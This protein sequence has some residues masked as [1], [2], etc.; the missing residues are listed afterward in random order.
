MNKDN[1]FIESGGTFTSVPNDKYQ[2]FFSKFLEIDTLNVADWKVAHVIGYFCKKYKDQYKVDYSWKFNNPSPSK[3]YEVWQAKTLSAKLSSN[4]K[5]LKNYID[6]IFANKTN[7]LKRR[8]TAISFITNDSF[9]FE[10]KQ[11]LLSGMENKINRA[12]ELPSE[13]K[14][15]FSK[16][17]NPI[18]T[19]GELAFIYQS[20]NLSSDLKIALEQIETLGFNKS[21][22][23]EIF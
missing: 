14:N 1:E 15:I 5:I 11:I 9:L 6:W 17:S 7:N 2:K 19:Y 22:I 16:T 12:S 18:N 3:C 20:N 23:K 21:L 10:Y 4:P 13:Y 8:F